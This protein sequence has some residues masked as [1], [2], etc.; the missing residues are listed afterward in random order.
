M[1]IRLAVNDGTSTNLMDAEAVR[2]SASQAAGEIAS[3]VNWGVDPISVTLWVIAIIAV[4]AV[5]Y[6]MT[7]KPYLPERLRRP[8]GVGP[9]THLRNTIVN[10]FYSFLA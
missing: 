3:T 4:G 5:W 1:F 8:V 9:M 10:K 2:N 7:E 6:A